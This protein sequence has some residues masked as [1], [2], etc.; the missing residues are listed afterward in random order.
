MYYRTVFQLG[1]RF[2]NQPVNSNNTPL[3]LRDLKLGE[4][5]LD[6][7]P[8]WDFNLH[9]LFRVVPGETASQ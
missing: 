6:P 5:I 2:L 1:L 3:F 8:L 7:R 4:E 9:T